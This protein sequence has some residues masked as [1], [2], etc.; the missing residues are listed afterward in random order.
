VRISITHG[1]GM[2]T[3]ASRRDVND[4]CINLLATL[5]RLGGKLR[6]FHI[7]SGAKDLEFLSQ[8]VIFLLAI[9]HK[10]TRRAS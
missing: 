4:Y 7:A 9:N 2:L 3:A 1:I 8:P 5:V 6:R 10:K